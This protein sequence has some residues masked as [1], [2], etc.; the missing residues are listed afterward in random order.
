MSYHD[1]KPHTNKWAEE[2]K[3]EET[4]ETPRIQLISPQKKLFDIEQILKKLPEEPMSMVELQ[5]AIQRIIDR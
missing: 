1:Y 3:K 2:T 4:T 5:E